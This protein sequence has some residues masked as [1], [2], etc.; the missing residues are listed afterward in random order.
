MAGCMVTV[1]RTLPH[2]RATKK[3]RYNLSRNNWDKDE[4]NA[5]HLF[6]AEER[7]VAGLRDL[8]QLIEC[9]RSDPRV[10]IVRGG[11]APETRAAI[12]L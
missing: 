11:L 5:G 7:P 1:M 3:L 8:A 6:T 10:F 12:G 2:L 4:Y 9:L